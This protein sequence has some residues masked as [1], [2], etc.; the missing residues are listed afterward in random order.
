MV[1]IDVKFRHYSDVSRTLLKVPKIQQS[2]YDSIV[3][4]LLTL[5]LMGHQDKNLQTGLVRLKNFRDGALYHFLYCK[6]DIV[7]FAPH[8]VKYV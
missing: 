3:E 1:G 7:I 2:F 5:L 8:S 4:K 6:L